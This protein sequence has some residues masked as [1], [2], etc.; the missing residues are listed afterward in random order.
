MASM[1]YRHN[2]WIIVRLACED[3]SHSLFLHKPTST[4]TETETCGPVGAG[5]LGRPGFSLPEQFPGGPR[6][7][8]KTA[9][10][11]ER[12]CQQGRA[13]TSRRL[14]TSSPPK[15]LSGVLLVIR[16]TMC[17]LKAALA[18]QHDSHPPCLLDKRV[19]K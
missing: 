19:V 15:R 10:Q 11:A 9:I 13:S 16:C 5:A 1:I 8:T 18:H 7:G 14:P 17:N 12:L 3:Q 6:G 2:E 4:G